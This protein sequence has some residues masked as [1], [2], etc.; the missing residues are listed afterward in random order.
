MI[1]DVYASAPTVGLCTQGFDDMIQGM[2]QKQDPACRLVI[3]RL[4]SAAIGVL[5]T[6]VQ[7]F[8][9]DLE[10]DN[11]HLLT[12]EQA[13]KDLNRYPYTQPAAVDSASVLVQLMLT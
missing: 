6:A 13:V 12:F 2:L 11:G 4:T 5:H 9:N 3:P 7:A 8:P 1:C 10:M